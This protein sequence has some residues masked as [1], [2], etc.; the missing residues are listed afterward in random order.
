MARRCFYIM[1]LVVL[2]LLVQIRQASACEIH[3]S[4]NPAVSNSEGIV[5][6]N[7]VVKWEHR[8]CLLATEEEM[9]IDPTGAEIIEQSGWRMVKRGYYVND[10]KLRLTGSEGSL[11]VWSECKKKGV[12]ES[13]V[14]IVRPQPVP[15]KN[16]A[17]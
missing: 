10:V 5:T 17:G 3:L 4:P 8:K 13:T 11:R 6:I 7:I 2:L 9:R 1:P 15:Q 12:S 14:K 16:W